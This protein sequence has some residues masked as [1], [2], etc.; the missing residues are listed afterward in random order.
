MWC[1]GVFDLLRVVL[2]RSFCAQLHRDRDSTC[3]ADIFA[4]LCPHRVGEMTSSHGLSRS[5][6]RIYKPCMAPWLPPPHRNLALSGRSRSSLCEKWLPKVGRYRWRSC[7]TSVH[8]GESFPWLHAHA[9]G[10]RKMSLRTP[11]AGPYGHW[12]AGSACGAYLDNGAERHLV[13][14]VGHLFLTFRQDVCTIFTKE[15]INMSA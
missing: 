1:D 14:N 4:D 3:Q 9:Q 12:P 8:P 15:K 2:V 6:T 7:N 5:R 10:C 13:N 11:S